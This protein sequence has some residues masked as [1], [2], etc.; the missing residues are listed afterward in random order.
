MRWSQI[1]VL[2]GKADLAV[3]ILIEAAHDNPEDGQVYYWLGY[4]S[5]LR[6]QPVD[7]RIM[8]NEC[9]RC[10]PDHPQAIQALAL[11]E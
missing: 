5:M 3:P 10:N 4:C 9:L 1:L 2:D 8:F 6:Q 11:L 7:A